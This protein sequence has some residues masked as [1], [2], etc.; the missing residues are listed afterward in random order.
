MSEL[1][2]LPRVYTDQPFKVGQSVAFPESVHHYL[3]N[4]MRMEQG[5]KLR[6]FNGKDGEFSATLSVLDKK[7][8]L[9][10]LDEKIREQPMEKREVHLLFAP[11]R[12]ERMDWLVEKSV[13]LGATHLHP[14]LTQ[15]TDL[16]KINEERMQAQ[17]IEAA[18]QCERLDIPVLS[19]LNDLFAVLAKWGENPQIYAALERYDASRLS[20]KLTSGDKN[21]LAILIGPSGGFTAEEIDR[22]VSKKFVIPV[23]LGDNIL[24]SETAALAALSLLAV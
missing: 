10:Q 11:I 3:R 18:E 8:A 6:L 20:E 5:G 7:N 17:I 21:A 14:V 13:E 23:N 19:P 2:K 22:I 4:V 1:Y 24:R 9:A 15:N 16:R 12:K